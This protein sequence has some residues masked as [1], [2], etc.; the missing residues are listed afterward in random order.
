MSRASSTNSGA[1]GS[2]N[3]NFWLTGIGGFVLGVLTV[4][5]VLALAR[6]TGD[7]LSHPAPVT[8]TAEAPSEELLQKQ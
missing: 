7:E 2:P 5:I 4:I 6:R 8:P 3:H 1:F